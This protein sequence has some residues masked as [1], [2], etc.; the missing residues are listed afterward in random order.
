MQNMGGPVQGLK[1]G[2][3][4]RAS[5]M[6]I[7]SGMRMVYPESMEDMY[8]RS[9]A[10]P[11]PPH[12]APLRGLNQFNMGAMHDTQFMSMNSI[13]LSAGMPE[14]DLDQSYFSPMSEVAPPFSSMHTTPEAQHAGLYGQMPTSTSDMPSQMPASVNSIG[15]S[16]SSNG[17]GS[18]PLP[19][20]APAMNGLPN[21]MPADLKNALSVSANIVKKPRQMLFSTEEPTISPDEIASF[22]SGPEPQDGK[23]VCL[24]GG[25]GKRFGRKEN[26]KS[27][28]QTH[29]GDRQ[30]KCFVCYK[31]FVRQHDLKRHSKI[32]TGVKPYQCQC[33]N[34]FA[35]HDALTRHRQRG[36][37]V[38]AFE[39]IVK[40]V[41]KR[42][43]PR[44]RPLPESTDGTDTSTAKAPSASKSGSKSSE[45]PSVLQSASSSMS[46]STR[47]NSRTASPES[48][49]SPPPLSPA[50]HSPQHF[51]F[52]SFLSD[53]PHPP[54][55]VDSTTGS[56]SSP[57]QLPTTSAE[58]NTAF[59]KY[60]LS[61]ENPIVT[62]AGHNSG[63]PAS[64]HFS[65]M[66]FLNGDM[67]GLA[68]DLL[69]FSGMGA[70][71]L[72]LCSAPEDSY[73]RPE[74]LGGGFVR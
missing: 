41:V 13:A 1:Q 52:N 46:G 16:D 34:S 47:E 53:S 8:A 70:G 56:S 42:G 26:I 17:Q 51:D 14:E 64:S 12:T 10:L 59:R 65:E 60:S 15:Q 9:D 27:H 28:V 32:H 58:Y 57:L 48:S 44:K 5:L 19:P 23:W 39:G 38:G 66:D 21:T 68:N 62:S 36:M 61:L 25:C 18:R 31:C 45:P 6:N 4:R 63:I 3:I 49:G 7:P 20:L 30:Y 22:I 69:D 43:R 54:Q 24:Y 40:K 50:P 35:R 33:G 67:G 72:G 73:I 29:L 37:C 2:H 55:L 74:V 71:N 11:T